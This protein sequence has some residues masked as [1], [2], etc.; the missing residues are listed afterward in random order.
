MYVARGRVSTGSRAAVRST[1][2]CDVDIDCLRRSIG[3]CVSSAMVEE[4]LLGRRVVQVI[5]R[6]TSVVLG[7]SGIKIG[8]DECDITPRG[9]RCQRLFRA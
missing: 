4:V 1:G 6:G 7:K 8:S 3:S 2:V 5:H 9:S